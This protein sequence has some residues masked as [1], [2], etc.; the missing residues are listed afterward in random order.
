MWCRARHC[1][2]QL[3]ILEVT[4]LVFFVNYANLGPKKLFLNCAS[5]AVFNK[6]LAYSNVGIKI[7][8]IVTF[9]SLFTREERAVGS[10][11]LFGIKTLQYNCLFA[12]Y[13]VGASGNEP[14]V[15]GL[16]VAYDFGGK[17][18]NF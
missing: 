9:K 3:F 17:G 14:L 15:W 10:D 1:S 6:D 11:V 13:T 16:S 18:F 8:P 12:L 4:V 5:L 2:M 7:K